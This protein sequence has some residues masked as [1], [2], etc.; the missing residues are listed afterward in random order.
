MEREQN[1]R[2]ARVYEAAKP[3]MEPASREA[4]L[5]NMSQISMAISMKRIADFICGGKDAEGID[6]MDVVSYIGREIAHVLKR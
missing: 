2:M 5:D 4:F 3:L 1:E 6:H